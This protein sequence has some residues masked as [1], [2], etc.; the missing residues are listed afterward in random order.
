MLLIT[1][2]AHCLYI[3]ADLVVLC[4]YLGENRTTGTGGVD[5]DMWETFPHPAEGPRLLEQCYLLLCL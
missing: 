5:L 3:P 2:V 4:L 1:K